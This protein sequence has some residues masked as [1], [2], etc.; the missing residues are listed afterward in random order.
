MET[1]QQFYMIQ[2]VLCIDV[3][4]L[5]VAGDKTSKRLELSM[6][7]GSTKSGAYPAVFPSD[8]WPAHDWKYSHFNPNAGIELGSHSDDRYEAVLIPSPDPEKEQ[9]IF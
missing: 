2:R 4:N 5:L 8:E 1:A 9:P 3:F 7:I 6:I